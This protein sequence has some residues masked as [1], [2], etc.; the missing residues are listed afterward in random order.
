MSSI[1]EQLVSHDFRAISDLSGKGCY[2]TYHNF[3][4]IR[5]MSDT[6]SQKCP[7][8]AGTGCYRSADTVH[9]LKNISGPKN[10]LDWV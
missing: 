4:M 7:V 2:V 8:G 1:I 3:E 5:F 9:Y 10:G 6:V